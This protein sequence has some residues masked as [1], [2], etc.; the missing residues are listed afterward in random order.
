MKKILMLGGLSFLIPVIEVAHRL[1]YKVI[2]CD[3]VPENIAHKYSDEYYNI[4]IIDKKKVLELAKTLK[5]D[6]ILSFAVDP[7]VVTAAYVQTKLNLPGSPY[8]SVVILQNK[9]LFRNFL[10]EHNFN[11]PFFKNYTSINELLKDKNILPYPIIIKPVDSAGSKGVSRVCSSEDLKNAGI[12]AFN[13]SFN[14]I[15]IAEEF[16]EPQNN[17]S[18]SDCFSVDGKMVFYSFSSQYFDNTAP[19]PYTPCAYSWPSTMNSKQIEYLKGEIQRL[20]SLLHM[21]TSIYNIET[22]VGKNGKPYIM[23]VSPR[24]GGNR[25]SEIVKHVYNIDLIE[26]AVKASVGN[27]DFDFSKRDESGFWTE[28]ILHSSKNGIFQG[29]IVD[30][31][32]KE[33]LY[34]STINYLTNDAICAF[35]G[36]NNMIGTLLFK[37]TN[38][39]QIDFLIENLNELIQVKVK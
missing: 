9:D 3:N 26:Y 36:A 34:N 24:G 31:S 35:N 23:E 28:V 17:P 29:V 25:L 27:N 14:K 32:L 22:R 33:Y 15:I 20:I 5:I 12:K 16:I 7:G 21:K 10:K 11:V 2:T 39:K 38:Q 19:N 30:N 6:G 13:N 18:D 8:E 37:F 4:S 1:G